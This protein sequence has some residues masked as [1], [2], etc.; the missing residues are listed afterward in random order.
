MD[1]GLNDQDPIPLMFQTGYLTIGNYDKD[2]DLYELRF[3]NQEVEIGFYEDLLKVYVP[4]TADSDTPF[5]FTL[6]K[7]ALT[8]GRICDFMERLSTL[9]KNIPGED[10]RE[11]TYRAI[12]YLIAVL[13]GSPAIAEHHGYKGRSD[14]EV[15]TR[16]YIYVFEFKYNKSVKEAMDQINSRDYAGRYAMDSRTVYL[17]AANYNESKDDRGLE[18]EIK[19]LK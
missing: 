12:T 18:F 19:K 16:R 3:P 5:R 11:S 8:T 10:H 2:D 4:D 13:S 7:T 1:V 17:I 15:F 6:F 9:L 14:M